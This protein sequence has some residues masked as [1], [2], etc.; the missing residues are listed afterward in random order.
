MSNDIVLGLD[1]PT[2]GP[3]LCWLVHPPAFVHVRYRIVL[4]PSEYTDNAL[5]VKPS[6]A[7]DIH[8]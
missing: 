7:T 2:E 3:S 6:K 8:G 1:P 5:L 4:P